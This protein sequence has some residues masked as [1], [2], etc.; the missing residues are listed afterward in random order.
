M[1]HSYNYSLSSG[2]DM[3]SSRPSLRHSHEHAHDVFARAARYGEAQGTAFTAG[4]RRVL[5]ALVEAGK[6]MSAYDLADR[7]SGG[8]RRVA[9]V[10]VYR[11][12]EFLIAAGVVH[13]LATRSSFVTCDH[14]HVRGETIVFLVCEGCGNVAEVTSPAVGR[15]LRGAAESTGFQPLNP[16]VEVEGRCAACQA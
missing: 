16:V 5:E 14:E 13:R 8:G 15:G 7:L 12:L 1:L 9:P 10:Q 4:R 11:S 6:P 2:G 3:A